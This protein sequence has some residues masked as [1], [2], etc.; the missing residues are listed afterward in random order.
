MRCSS[1]IGYLLVQ[2]YLEATVAIFNRLTNH[3]PGLALSLKSATWGP[4]LCRRLGCRY[5]DRP[6]PPSAPGANPTKMCL[7]TVAAH[8]DFSWR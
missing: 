6:D 4:N 5:V 3:T 1:S 7:K 2:L 8:S